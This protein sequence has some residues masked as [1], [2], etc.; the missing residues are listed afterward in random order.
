LFSYLYPPMFVDL[1]EVRDVFHVNWEDNAREAIL[2]N[3]RFA[4]SNAS[5]GYGR[6]FWGISASDGPHGYQG[7][8]GTP[9]LDPGAFGERHDGTVAPYAVA[10]SLPYAADLA[11]PALE[12]LAQMSSGRLYGRYGL[13]SGVNLIKNFFDPNYLG[14]DQGALLL[15]IEDF[16]TGL[17]ASLVQQSAP[18]QRA[19]TAL[20]FHSA[21]SVRLHPEGPRSRRAYVPVDTTDH[22]VQT[23]EMET[24]DLSLSGDALI[25]L[26]P[27]GMDN[28]HGAR[29]V[30]IDVS[31]NGNFLETVRF[32][33][34]RSTGTVDVGSVYVPVP[35]GL[36]NA[37]QSNQLQL[38]WVAGERWL[39]IVDI[40][41]VAPTG[42]KGAQETWEAG[43]ENGS[44]DEFTS[45]RDVDDSYIVGDPPAT[46]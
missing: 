23:V 18:L 43:S 13:R 26:H 41:G 19:F 37:G 16:R 45:E 12:H 7:L 6:T 27:Y 25:E 5:F 10:G 4:Q 21:G 33:D 30:D 31:L 29:F 2:A 8:Y 44:S 35:Q 36:W 15:G 34:R 17:I 32:V 24:P 14:L 11:L 42:R 20:G 1:G 46:P 40:E 22:L 3:F 38:Q 39:Q 28:A 9:P